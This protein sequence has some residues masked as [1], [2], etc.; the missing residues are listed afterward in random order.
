MK[1]TMKALAEKHCNPAVS[2]PKKIGRPKKE[3]TAVKRKTTAINKASAQHKL[4]RE[5][6]KNVGKDY[7]EMSPA[8]RK[9]AAKAAEKARNEIYFETHNDE[10]TFKTPLCR[11][12]RF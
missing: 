6:Y 12:I 4:I 9:S 7:S 10:P 5:G 11:P 2:A 3:L 1:M 8:E